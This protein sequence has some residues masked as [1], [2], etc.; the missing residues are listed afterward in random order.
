MCHPALSLL[1]IGKFILT[2]I[3]LSIIKGFYY[4]FQFENI[5]IRSSDHAFDF[6]LIIKTYKFIRDY[7]Q[8]L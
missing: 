1:A 4:N 8:S 2:P 3:K 7:L 5:E 6:V